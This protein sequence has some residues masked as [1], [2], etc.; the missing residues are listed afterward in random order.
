M[1]AFIATRYILEN[2]NKKL[3]ILKESLVSKRDMKM[4]ENAMSNLDDLNSE[5]EYIQSRLRIIKF[6]S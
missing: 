5:I 4:S 1:L 6:H 3:H 2:K